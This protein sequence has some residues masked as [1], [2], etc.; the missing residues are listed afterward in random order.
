MEELYDI[1]KELKP[2]V[3]F[4]TQQHLIDDHILDSMEI[5]SLVMDLNEEFDVEITPL[6]VIPE[7]FQSADA[8][9]R[10]I[11]RLQNAD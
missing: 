4:R 8:I 5:M 6:E 3:D 1:L 11:T 7:N 2:D 9:Y 10:M